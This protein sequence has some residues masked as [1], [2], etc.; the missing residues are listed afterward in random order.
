[1]GTNLGSRKE[2]ERYVDRQIRRLQTGLLSQGSSY[3]RAQL[4]QLRRGLTLEP[5]DSPET[6]DIEFSGL[7]EALQGK[8]D[9]SPTAGEWAVH[10]A[11][12]L[13]AT[14]QQSQQHEMYRKT[15]AGSQELYGLGHSVKR[16]AIINNANNQG[17]Q[18]AQGEMPRRFKALATAESIEELAHYARQ[19]I[20]QLRAEGIPLDYASFAG[21]VFD[22]QNPYQRNRVRLEWAREFSQTLPKANAHDEDGEQP[23]TN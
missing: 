21:Q 3:A 11:L 13:Y 12:A 19:L 8:G 22:Y 9:S 20:T 4:A 18:L 16:L 10:L 23:S 7:P 14:H 2:V 6:W 5:G 1:M 15:D 17:E